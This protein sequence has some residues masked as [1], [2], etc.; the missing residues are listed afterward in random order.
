M[1]VA[2]T[3]LFT[4]GTDLDHSSAYQFFLNSHVNIPWNNGFVVAFNIVLRDNAGVF[5]SGLVKEVYGVSFLKK[6][7]TDVF[8]LRRILLMVLVCRLG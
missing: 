6:C 8:L 1:I 5:N 4:I 7:I 3:A 2:V